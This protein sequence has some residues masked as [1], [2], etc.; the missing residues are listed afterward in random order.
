MTSRPIGRIPRSR[1][2]RACGGSV[3]W[4][5][6]LQG[7]ALHTLNE[8]AAAKAAFDRMLANA[9]GNQRCEWTEIALWLSSDSAAQ[10]AYRARPC[11]ERVQ[12]DKKLFRLAQPLWGLPAND[13]H[14]ELM[15]R[16][17][18]SEIH[19]MGRIPYDLT[20]GGDLLESQL[21]YGWPVNWSVQNGGVG[22]PR[23]PSVIGHEPTPSYDFFQTPRR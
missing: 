19:A 17:T 8:H 12:S 5:A 2:A 11:D 21:R 16:H 7:L 4:C 3:W 20:F 9:P 22:D 6:A 23:P 13:L 1:R 14:N 15:A 10:R 18:M